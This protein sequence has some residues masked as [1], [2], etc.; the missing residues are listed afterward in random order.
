MTYSVD[1]TAVGVSSMNVWRTDRISSATVLRQITLTN[2]WSTLGSRWLQL[3]IH[4]H[5]HIK[6]RNV[7]MRSTTKRAIVLCKSATDSVR[8]CNFNNCYPNFA[9]YSNTELWPKTIFNMAFVHLIGFVVM[10]SYC[11]PILCSY[12][13]ASNFLVHWFSSDSVGLSYLGGLGSCIRW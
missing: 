6:L 12:N 8:L 10:S 1:G 5:K 7:A 11:T 3:F 13:S 9:L 4:A 2:D